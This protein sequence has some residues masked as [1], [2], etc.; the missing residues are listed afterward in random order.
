M[1]ALAALV[2][3]HWERL[4]RFRSLY[5]VAAELLTPD[6]L[7]AL[8]DPL[9]GPVTDAIARGQETGE[10]RSDLPRTWLVASL[11]ALMHQAADEVNAGRLSRDEAGSVLAKSIQA[12]FADRPLG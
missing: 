7:R 5:A 11:Y 8:H 6:R 9:F 4:A 10:V 3:A 1:K 2:D 12:L